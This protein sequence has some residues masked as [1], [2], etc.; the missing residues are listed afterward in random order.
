MFTGDGLIIGE[1][2]DTESKTASFFCVDG[3]TGRTLWSG[4]DFGEAWWIGLL[5]VKDGTLYLH[6]FKKPDMPEHK[7]IFAVDVRTGQLRWKNSDC[8]FLAVAENDVFG[9]KDLFERRV[10]Y[11]IDGRTGTLLEELTA[12]PDSVDPN[13]R[14]ERTDF[15]FPSPVPKEAIPAP[16]APHITDAVAAEYVA[17][18]RYTV[19]NTHRRNT[20][21][22]EGLTNRVMVIGNDGHRVL[23]TDTLNSATPYPVPDSFFMDGDR[24][25]YIK[26]RT[27]LTAVRLKP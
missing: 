22:A 17:G 20:P 25:Y 1:D 16:V 10:F 14:Y 8:A 21:P 11:R 19:L 12:L 7:H 6:G 24:L 15:R 3:S 9:F 18:E 27:T 5:G 2:R 26:E 23:F 4:K 13:E